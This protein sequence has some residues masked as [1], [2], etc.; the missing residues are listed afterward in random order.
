MEKYKMH[1]QLVK[2]DEYKIIKLLNFYLYL[3]KQI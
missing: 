1:L 3:L 2:T